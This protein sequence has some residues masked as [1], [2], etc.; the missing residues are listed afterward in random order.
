MGN[1]ELK[2]VRHQLDS[3]NLQRL[4]GPLSVDDE[5]RYRSLCRQERVLLEAMETIAIGDH[6]LTLS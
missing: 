4:D 6:T 5:H 1:Q 3:L 2:F